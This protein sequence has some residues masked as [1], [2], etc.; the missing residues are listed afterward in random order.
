MARSGTTTYNATGD[1]IIARALRLCG[2]AQNGVA[3]STTD[4]TNAYLALNALVKSLQ[5]E[6]YNL[7]AREWIQKT[8]TASSIVTGSDGKY[9]ECI[10]SHTSGSTTEPITGANYEAFWL[11]TT[12]EIWPPGGVYLMVLVRILRKTT[13]R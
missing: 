1:T 11:E 5:N 6:G 2:V 8:L 10:K 7:W 9:Y 4:K 13:C 12:H 3:A